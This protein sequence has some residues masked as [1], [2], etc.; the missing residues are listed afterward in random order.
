M[1]PAAT[2]LTAHRRSRNAVSVACHGQ[3]R[4][5]QPVAGACDGAAAA[6]GA[7]AADPPEARPAAVAVRGAG[8]AAFV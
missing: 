8:P 2:R 3:G 4:H 1:A 6:R 5:D 7:A